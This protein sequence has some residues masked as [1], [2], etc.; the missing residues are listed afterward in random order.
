[1][2]LENVV[3]THL[4]QNNGLREVL[5]NLDACFYRLI[6]GSIQYLTHTMHDITHTLNLASQYMLSPNI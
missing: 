1:M 3:D 4:A 5:G 6:V 2:N